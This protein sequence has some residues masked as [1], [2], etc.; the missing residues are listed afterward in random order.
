M[1]KRIFS[2]VISLCMVLA[3]MPQMVF[4]EEPGNY[5]ELQG[6]MKDARYGGTV[7]LTKDYTINNYEVGPM[8]HHLYDTLTGI[9]WGRVA[10]THNWVFPID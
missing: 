8:A 4:A 1:K 7:T 9:Q 6:I 10:D 5:D 2:I 3:L